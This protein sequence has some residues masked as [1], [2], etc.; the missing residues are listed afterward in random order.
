[1]PYLLSSGEVLRSWNWRIGRSGRDSHA[2]ASAALSDMLEKN[3]AFKVMIVHGM[4]DLV[5]PYLTSRYVIDRLPPTLTKGRV[6]QS[7]LP[8]GHMMYL[9]PSS[10]AGL[11]ADAASFYPAPK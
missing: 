2:G 5:T 11:H 3:G 8:G 4:T 9:R 7:L 6:T 1:M 10:R